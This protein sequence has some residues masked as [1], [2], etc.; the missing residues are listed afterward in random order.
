M[1]SAFFPIFSLILGF[2]AVF[3][4]APDFTD[5]E[6]EL[7]DRASLAY[8][9]K[10]AQDLV[11]NGI[12][13][14]VESFQNAFQAILDG[15]TALADKSAISAT[16]GELR[17]PNPEIGDELKDR[18]GK[19]YGTYLAEELTEDGVYLNAEKL[20]KAFAAVQDGKDPLTDAEAVEKAFGEVNGFLGR[21]KIEAFA[22]SDNA[23]EKKNARYLLDNAKKDGVHWTA[24]GMQFKVLN[25]ADGPKPKASDRVKVHYTGKLIDGTVFD[26]STGGEPIEFGLGGVIPGWTEGLQLM[27]AG[28]K[29][30]LFIPYKLG[31]RETGSPPKIPGY[32]T[33]VFDVELL[34][35]NP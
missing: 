27:G 34:E 9:T 31:Y 35:I 12:S 17:K 8:G 32:A 28:S 21:R 20:A 5:E 19:A 2:T 33:L 23:V 30:R 10:L 7:M 3:A 14:D 16:F 6:R 1:K 13:L 25:E 26:S 15:E 18:A 11:K 22:E 29:Y 24:S 4:Q